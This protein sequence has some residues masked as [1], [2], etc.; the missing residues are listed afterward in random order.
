MFKNRKIILEKNYK[1]SYIRSMKP[2]KGQRLRDLICQWPSGA[3]Y[4]QIYLT[5]AGYSADLVKSY[6]KAGWIERVG[7][8]AFK[9]CGD[10]VDWMGGMYAVQQQLG[11]RVH[12]GGRTALALQGYAHYGRMKEDAAYLFGSHT[13]R[14]P[15]WFK[16]RDWGIK[17]NYKRT[18]FLPYDMDESFTEYRHRGVTIRISSLERAI[19]EVVYLTPSEHGFDEAQKL[20][21]L[22]AALRPRVIQSLLERCDSVRTKRLFL[23]LAEKADHPWFRRLDV[24]AIDLGSGNRMLVEGGKLNRKYMISV[25]IQREKGREKKHLE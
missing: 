23:Y 6:R 20:M 7:T 17:L 1:I 10:T 14:L 18:I 15:K 4:T 19:I 21:E 25:P 8:G 16:V 9:R 24:G 3:V 11:I 22:L 5:K 2:K 12:A 13:V